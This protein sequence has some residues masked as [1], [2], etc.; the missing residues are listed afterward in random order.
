MKDNSVT[1]IK[2]GKLVDIDEDN[3][4][5]NDMVVV[6]LGDIAPADLRSNWKGD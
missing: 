4:C 2:S 6:Q 3:L 1:I 5:K